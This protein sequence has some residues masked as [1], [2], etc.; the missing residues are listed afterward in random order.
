M[1]VQITCLATPLRHGIIAFIDKLFK[2]VVFL[3]GAVFYQV[4]L[5]LYM[6][7]PPFLT[8]VCFETMGCLLSCSKHIIQSQQLQIHIL[9][10]N[11]YS[12]GNEELFSHYNRHPSLPLEISNWQDLHTIIACHQYIRQK[13]YILIEATV[14]LAN[15]SGTKEDNLTD[16]L[17]CV[18][19]V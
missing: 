5:S 3:R 9:A 10:N 16:W 13:A 4:R 1:Y 7:L 8:S 11:C 19:V 14:Y 18:L 2:S 6:H 17:Y 12:E 15:P